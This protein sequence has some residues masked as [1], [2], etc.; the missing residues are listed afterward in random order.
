MLD[1]AYLALMSACLIGCVALVDRLS[2]SEES[3]PPAE[4]TGA[5]R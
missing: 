4:T 5:V 3:I 1:I 2:R